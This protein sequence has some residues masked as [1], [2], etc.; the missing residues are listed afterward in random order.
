LSF[1]NRISDN[2][3][4]F[5]TFTNPGAFW[6]MS[7]SQVRFIEAVVMVGHP[8]QDYKETKDFSLYFNDATD[9]E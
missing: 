7:F 8:W 5:V 4:S 1:A 9:T 6:Q 2:I 3:N